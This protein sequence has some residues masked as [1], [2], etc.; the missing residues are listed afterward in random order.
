[1]K[2]KCNYWRHEITLITSTARCT[3]IRIGGRIDHG[4]VWQHIER[5]NLFF[6]IRGD[7]ATR[8]L[9]KKLKKKMKKK[10]I[11]GVTK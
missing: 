4:Q 5:Y 2:K 8:T 11:I 9:T 3:F 6:S 1:M 10:V 7:I